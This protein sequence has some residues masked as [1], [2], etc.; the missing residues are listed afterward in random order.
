MGKKQH[1]LIACKTEK[2]MKQSLEMSSRQLFVENW[3][4]VSAGNCQQITPFKVMKWMIPPG[5][6][7]RKIKKRAEWVTHGTPQH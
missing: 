6:E 5:K 1:F 7:Y 4:E 3:H 2:L